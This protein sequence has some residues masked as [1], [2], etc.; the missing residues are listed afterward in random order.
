MATYDQSGNVIP[1]SAAY[2]DT[3]NPDVA[4]MR[5]GAGPMP[6]YTTT[7][8]IGG[9]DW[10]YFPKEEA[11]R[12]GK[13]QAAMDTLAAL[14]AQIEEQI[15][16]GVQGVKDSIGVISPAIVVLGIIWLV[17]QFRGR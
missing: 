4:K 16:A 7:V 2:Y 12:M 5:A 14:P 11:L 1:E 8:N 6:E 9:I 13:I 15:T 10:W 17:S 3:S